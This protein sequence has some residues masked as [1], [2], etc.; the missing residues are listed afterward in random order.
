ME[1]ELFEPAG[2]E[3]TL[4]E[5]FRTPDCDAPFA[6]FTNDWPERFGE[7]KHDGW[8]E[9]GVVVE[10]PG[11][12]DTEGG[13]A[14]MLNLSRQREDL[15]A[16]VQGLNI[17]Q[18]CEVIAEGI[19]AHVITSKPMRR[20]RMNQGLETRMHFR[21]LSGE[22]W[23]APPA[24]RA[25]DDPGE[26]KERVKVQSTWFTID[27]PKLGLHEQGTALIL[28]GMFGTPDP[29][30]Q[31]LA[32]RL[33]DRG[34]WVVRMVSQPSRFTERMNYSLDPMNAESAAAPAKEISS[35]TAEC[36]YAVA[37]VLRELEA[38]QPQLAGKPR[39][40]IGLSAGA[41]TLPTVVAYEPERYCGAVL[42]AG[43]CHYWLMSQT[44]NYS[45]WIDAV[46]VKWLRPPT[47][48][49]LRAFED[50]YLQHATLDSFHTAKAMHGK[51]MLVI[52]GSRDLA[53]PSP[54]GDCLWQRLGKPEREL[55]PVGH[56]LIAMQLPS[57]FG[58]ITSF[59]D[60]S[61][62]APAEHAP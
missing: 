49:E 27:P 8:T 12:L 25:I 46:R 48:Q 3:R 50:S 19:G 56:E 43:G 6:D 10:V 34:W 59:C 20:S 2:V 15:R 44:S 62:L 4:F 31:S 51:P 23:D 1:P 58:K 53:V 21:F 60:R 29:T 30:L 9:R 37:H 33:R 32:R 18:A 39:V 7:R 38:R 26:F 42:I 11:P 24:I 35:R 47:S 55:Y 52:Q 28:P 61:A 16:L 36:A 22:V 5:N 13:D 45:R 54:L 17:S 41:M 40:A 57:Q 14:T